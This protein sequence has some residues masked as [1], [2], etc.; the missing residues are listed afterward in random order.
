MQITIRTLNALDK[1]NMETHIKVYREKQLEIIN[2]LKKYS[3]DEL[4]RLPLRRDIETDDE[5]VEMWVTSEKSGDKLFISVN[6]KEKGGGTFSA[7]YL[8]GF[9]VEVSSKSL[10][11]GFVTS[12]SGEITPMHPDKYD[13]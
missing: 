10:T 13:D 4:L 7:P 1:N 12:P 2:E 11:D 6:V 3:F 9:E 8:D 5:N